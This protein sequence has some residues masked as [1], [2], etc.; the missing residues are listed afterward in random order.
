[1]DWAQA[2]NYKYVRVT[3]LSGVRTCVAGAGETQ[4]ILPPSGQARPVTLGM[5]LRST[6][7]PP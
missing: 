1:M 5:R 2:R 4:G 3:A 7:G 6:D